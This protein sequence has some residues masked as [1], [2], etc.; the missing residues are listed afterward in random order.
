LSLPL[1]TPQ[2]NRQPSSV[3]L[4]RIFFHG[5]CSSMGVFPEQGL[6]IGDDIESDISGAQ[7][8]GLKNRTD[9]DR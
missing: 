8:A 5:V 1:N 2:E 7:Q 4:Q 3:N 9:T 6:I